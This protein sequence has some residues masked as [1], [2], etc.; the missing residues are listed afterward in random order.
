MKEF[1]PGKNSLRL[2]PWKVLVKFAAF[3]GKQNAYEGRKETWKTLGMLKK[4]CW[5]FVVSLFK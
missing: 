3:A 2:K 5:K 1:L 4:S